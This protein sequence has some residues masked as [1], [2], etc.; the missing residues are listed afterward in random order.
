[1]EA[2]KL[3]VSAVVKQTGREYWAL[4]LHSRVTSGN[5][6]S[7]CCCRSG[8]G[9]AVAAGGGG[10]SGRGCCRQWGEEKSLNGTIGH[11]SLHELLPWPRKDGHPLRYQLQL[12]SGLTLSLN[13]YC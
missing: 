4:L 8:G 13:Y 3:A 7:T 5:S 2:P 12:S 1:M 6:V 10:G 11:C 9:G